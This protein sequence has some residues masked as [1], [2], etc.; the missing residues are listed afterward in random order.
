[1]DQI[2]RRQRQAE[3]DWV[4]R[5]MQEARNNVGAPIGDYSKASSFDLKAHADIGDKAAAFEI[6]RRRQ[7]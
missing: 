1:M 3:M 6:E 5:Q 2:P 4:Q 7:G